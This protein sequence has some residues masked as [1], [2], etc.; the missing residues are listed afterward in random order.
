MSSEPAYKLVQ[1]A[2]GVHSLHSLEYRETLHPA[3]GPVAEAEVLY[4]R[5]L[6]LIERLRRHEGEFV[7]WDVGL[8]AAANALTI[9]R[10]GE[11]EARQE[12]RPVPCAI[13]LLSFDC[14]VEPLRFALQH[15]ETLG[16][17][18]DFEP[19]LRQLMDTGHTSFHHGA[20]RIQWDLHLADF[21]TLLGR[22]EARHLPKPHAILFDPY[23]PTTNPA[24]WTLPLFT[25]LF[26]LLNPGSP[27][28]LTTYS[29]GTLLR[30]TLL[31]AGFFVGPG[32]AS[33][34]KEETTIAANTLDLIDLPL[35]EDW[36]QRAR[37]SRSAEPMREPVHRQAPLSTSTWEQL[38]RHPQWDK[39]RRRR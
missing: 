24:M 39:I 6:R 8:G 14:T 19:R 15:K 30:V 35:D 22:T 32:R 27:C 16:Y 38:A 11:T 28:A 21:P 23:S 18:N 34:R 3:I 31:L 17:F 4:V 1:L 20:R 37:R 12:P 2:N 36:L 25:N 33:G 7:I 29:R 5:Q 9:V 13:R 26:Q 10:A